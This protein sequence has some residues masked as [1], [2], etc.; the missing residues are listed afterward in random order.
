MINREEA[1]ELVFE[2]IKQLASVLHALSMEAIKIEIA[3]RIIMVDPL[4]VLNIL[5]FLKLLY[6]NKDKWIKEMSELPNEENI[7]P[8]MMN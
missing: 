5:D 4:F 7:I 6:R 1:F 3:N 2:E 8:S